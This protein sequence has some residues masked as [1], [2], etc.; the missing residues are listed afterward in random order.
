MAQLLAAHIHIVRI[1]DRAAFDLLRTAASESNLPIRDVT[2][3]CVLH[4]SATTEPVSAPKLHP[5]LDLNSVLL[6]YIQINFSDNGYV[7]LLRNIKNAPDTVSISDRLTISPGNNT[8]EAPFFAL[9]ASCRR[10]FETLDKTPVLEQ[11]NDQQRQY[12]LE[13]QTSLHRLERMQDDFFNK[14]QEFTIG[15]TRNFQARQKELEDKFD[16]RVTEL[17][18]THEGKLTEL[19]EE[20]KRLDEKRQTMDL[21]DSTAVRRSIREDVKEMLLKRAASF[22][23]S[24]TAGRRRLPI[25]AAY[26]FLS[27]VLGIFAVY[28]F[29]T[30]GSDPAA[31][32]NPYHIGRLI[33]ATVGFVLSLSFFIR[34]LNDWSQQHADEEFYMKRFELDFERASFVVEWALEW[35]KEKEE[36][37]PYLIERLSR[38][39]FDSHSGD[40]APSTAADAL[41]SALFGSAATAKLKIGDNEISLDR[42]GIRTLKK[43][44]VEGE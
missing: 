4:Q 42:K 39:L 7:Q 27:G 23:L 15:Q 40:P 14:L 24:D 21:R 2:W 25:A 1:P 32:I 5:V 11:I 3:D 37:P 19:D 26:V 30:T 41:A 9:L 31:A 13:R 28:L 12:L 17:N 33:I 44:E 38:N 22:K 10:L 34:W 36:V 35:A 16:S 8:S 43:S 18:K 29:F 6:N 20:K